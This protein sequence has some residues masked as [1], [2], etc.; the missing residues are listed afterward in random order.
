MLASSNGIITFS[1]YIYKESMTG[2][3]HVVIIKWHSIVAFFSFAQRH[4][5][6]EAEDCREVD[7]NGKVCREKMWAVFRTRQQT[8]TSCNWAP[9]P[10]EWVQDSWQT[11]HSGPSFVASNWKDYENVGER[12]RQVDW[13]YFHVAHIDLFSGDAWVHLIWKWCTRRCGD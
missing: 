10:M 7:S 1:Q 3:V 6:V 13:I 11:I 8:G 2:Y 12:E 5:R 4:T 9:V